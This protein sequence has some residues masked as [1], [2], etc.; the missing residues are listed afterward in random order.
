MII[1]SLRVKLLL[2]LFIIY[3]HDGSLNLF[4]IM[5]L[6]YFDWGNYPEILIFP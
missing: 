3:I 2:F 6:H 4:N 1:L 5:I